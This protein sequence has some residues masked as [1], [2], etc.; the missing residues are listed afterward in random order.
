MVHVLLMREDVPHFFY[1]L[2]PLVLSFYLCTWLIMFSLLF[3]AYIMAIKAL[4]I[5]KS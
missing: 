2:Y 1:F 5:W 3:F 4:S